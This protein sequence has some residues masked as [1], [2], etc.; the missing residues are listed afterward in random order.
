M[1]IFD[2]T[3][4]RLLE[5]LADIQRGKIQLPDFQRSWVWDDNRIKGLIAS[6]IKSFPISVVTLLETGN[7]TVHFKTRPIQGAEITGGIIPEFLILDGQQRLTSLYQAIITNKVVKT[8]NDQGFEIKRWYYID[9]KKAMTPGYDLEESIFSINEN[10]QVTE[11]IG[12]DIVLD[13]SSPEKEYENFMYPVCK[14]DE[15]YE[16]RSGFQEFW[17]Y[18]PDQTKFY[19]EFD[20]RIIRPF[21]SYDVPVIIMKKENSKEAVCQVF[22]KVNTGGVSLNVFELLTATFAADGFN[23]IDEWKAI[24]EQF[25]V[26]PVLKNTSNTDLIQAVTLLSTYKKRTAMKDSGIS[27]DK[28]P[29]VSAKRK[30]MLDLCVEDFIAYKDQIVKGFLSAAQ[31][32]TDNYIFTARDLPYTTQLIPMSAIISVLGKEIENFNNRKKLMQWYWCGVFGE[33]YGSANETRYALDIQQV[34]EWILNDGKEPTTVY[35]ANFVPSRLNTLRTRNSAAYKGIYALLM[36]EDTKD[37]LTGQKI[38]I[39]TYFADSIDIHHIFPR[40]WDQRNNIP[41]EFYDSIVNKTPLCKGTNIFVSGDAP[42]IYLKRLEKKVHASEEDVDNLVETHTIDPALL[43]SDDFYAFFNTR[44][45]AILKKIEASTGKA[46]S[47]DNTITEEGT[48][49]PDSTAEEDTDEGQLELFDD[50]PDDSNDDTISKRPSLDYFRM[51]I[52]MNE[53]L[54]WNTDPTIK[55]KIIGPKEVEFNGIRQSLTAVTRIL[56]NKPYNENPTPFWSY[57][58]KIL[59]NIYDETYPK[60]K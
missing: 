6:V 60:G 41:V 54:T 43:R 26:S 28:L 9:M 36:D 11:N 55:V 15:D 59:Q 17:D 50:S 49:I 14:L 22:E 45:E 4:K 10:K 21:G 25:K 3:K 44:K 38:D 52:Q 24:Q 16:W 7:D 34:V 53:Y 35:D 30:S 1:E 48:Y 40:I 56:R 2:S 12:R 5:I 13:L 57:N 29:A 20:K 51:G 33:L 47:R 39:H 58:G 23:L 32:L 18:D 8:R 37:W 31:L 27:Q 46:I 42:S 19:N